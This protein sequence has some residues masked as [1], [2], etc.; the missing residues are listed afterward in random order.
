MPRST[1]LHVYKTTK[2]CIKFLNNVKI[3][4]LC[5]S[6]IM[7]KLETYDYMYMCNNSVSHDYMYMCNNSV[8]HDYMYMCN[9]SVSHDYM[10][11][12]NNSVSRYL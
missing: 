11:M 2:K 10:Y 1:P 12:C 6:F 4:H 8:S 5:S 9:N 7:M 3:N